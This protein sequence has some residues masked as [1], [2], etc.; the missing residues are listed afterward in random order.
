MDNVRHI[1]IR[2]IPS[3]ADLEK[4]LESLIKEYL[5]ETDK[6]VGE[7]NETIKETEDSGQ[8]SS[9]AF[10]KMLNYL[11]TLEKPELIELL[12]GALWHL[13]D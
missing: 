10:A 11:A 13:A 3:D 12:A 4:F 5:D 7:L 2:K 9:F 1:G 8:P 6:T